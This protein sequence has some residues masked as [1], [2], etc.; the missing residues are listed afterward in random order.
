MKRKILSYILLTLVVCHSAFNVYAITSDNDAT[1]TPSSNANANK[2]FIK[3]N[4]TVEIDKEINMT[5][6]L[7][8]IPYDNFTFKLYSN[9]S[10]SN[11]SA[12]DIDLK[13]YNNEEISF[14]YCVNC[15]SL[16][17]ISLNYKLPTDIEIGN[18]ITFN[19]QLINKDNTE[20]VMN[21]R[22]DVTVIESP[23]KEE[24]ETGEKEKIIEEKNMN[25]R[26]SFSGSINFSN[27]FSSSTGTKSNVSTTY[28][29]SSNN[30]LKTISIKGYKLNKSFIKERLTYFVTV[31]NN[32]KSLNISTTRENSNAFVNI[33]GNSNF[34]VGINK[35]LIT[36][37]AQDGRVRNYR[38]YVT[39]MDSDS[40]EK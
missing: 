8:N 35:V 18:K 11:V 16:K 25:K 30:Y 10:L 34:S 13:N 24:E 22:G 4:K 29:G 21:Y 32:V 38:I 3:I 39:R 9:N 17:T 27:S 6:Y 5:L 14:D 1:I 23:K 33:S 28:K 26:S 2:D 7:D 31:P 15:S 40:S 36:V 12:K 19:V 37:T 20:E